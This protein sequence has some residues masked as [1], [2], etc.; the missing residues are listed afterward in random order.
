MT[1]TMTPTLVRQLAC[2]YLDSISFTIGDDNV[3]AAL[4]HVAIAGILQF[5]TR[6]PGPVIRQLTLGYTRV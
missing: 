6:E 1:S 5:S 3:T 2:Q 4:A